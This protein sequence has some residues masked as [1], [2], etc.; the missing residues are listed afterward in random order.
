MNY[1]NFSQINFDPES[2]YQQILFE[3]G[4][5]L[6]DAELNEAGSIQAFE[7]QQLAKQ[8]FPEHGTGEGAAFKIENVGTNSVNLGVGSYFIQG[9]RFYNDDD[10]ADL[11]IFDFETGQVLDP[12][13]AGNIYLRGW[14]EEERVDEGLTSILRKRNRWRLE[15][16]TENQIFKSLKDEL[17]IEELKTPM[18]FQT[19]FTGICRL[20]LHEFDP[21][22][23]AN[24][25][26]KFSDNNGYGVVT[27]KIEQGLFQFSGE[28]K[29]GPD[30]HE[31]VLELIHK[32]DTGSTRSPTSPGPLLKIGSHD[33]R[34]GWDFE[35]VGDLPDDANEEYNYR[36]W[37]KV[38]T[39][40]YFFENVP[41][42]ENLQVGDYLTFE[43]RDGD[44]QKPQKRR[45]TRPQVFAQIGRL[46]TPAGGEITAQ[47]DRFSHFG[48]PIDRFWAWAA[49]L[50]ADAPDSAGGNSS[51]RGQSVTALP[52]S[53]ESPSGNVEQEVTC[54]E[55][56]HERYVESLALRDPVLSIWAN[57][58]NCYPL[59]HWLASATIGSIAKEPTLD[60]LVE[61]ILRTI[62]VPNSE[63]SQ[64]DREVSEI[65]QFVC[66]DFKDQSNLVQQGVSSDS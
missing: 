60:S 45:I 5:H 59:Q 24:A 57:P 9:L 18:L 65:Y 62:S 50:G 4:K 12:I 22:D 46:T 25:L 38:E 10:E 16:S 42:L 20:E 54:E 58:V 31:M 19:G 49:R 21:S 66:K 3:Q 41:E 43:V 51:S 64:F 29:N 53:I 7:L 35:P 55:V 47:E 28:S 8:I 27:G 17:D 11:S 15:H 39:P 32:V 1:G 6:T 52:D 48:I 2:N 13:V 34:L 23:Q 40:S 14:V 63:R 30:I 61:K 37:S 26:I 44:I 56:N 33:G 36:V